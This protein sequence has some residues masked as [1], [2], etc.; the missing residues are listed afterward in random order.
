MP[1]QI[2][3]MD[4]LMLNITQEVHVKASLEKTFESLLDQLGPY[5]ETPEGKSLQMKLEAW[6]GG[7]WYRDLGD[8]NGHFW[9]SVQA[10]K[11]PTLLEIS[12][13]L[14]ASSAFISNLQ[15][16]LSE[17]DGGTLI[18]LRHSALGVLTEDQRKGVS[19]GWANTLSRVKSRA[20]SSS[21]RSASV[22]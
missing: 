20:E 16:R 5:N 14:F 17:R 7:R 13:P 19:H 1:S 3:S 22:Q 9:G 10:I 2:T 6:P 18:T 4:D 8:S 12:G 21:A 11:R 15:Y